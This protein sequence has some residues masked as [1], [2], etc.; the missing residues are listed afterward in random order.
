MSYT[1]RGLW[2]DIQDLQLFLV[3]GVFFSYYTN[4]DY[5]FEKNSNHPVL[6]F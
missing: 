2:Y 5:S 1:L 6:S 4:F 3:R